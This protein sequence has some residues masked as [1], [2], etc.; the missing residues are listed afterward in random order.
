MSGKKY[1]YNYQLA[2]FMM[3]QGVRCLGCGRHNKSKQIYFIFNYDECQE[4]YEIW[5]KREH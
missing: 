4:A 2:N 3:E 1:I 5:N